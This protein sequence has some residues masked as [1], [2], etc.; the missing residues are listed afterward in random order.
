[1]KLVVNATEL[2]T[3]AIVDL[4]MHAAAELPGMADVM[5]S[6][7]VEAVQAGLADGREVTPIL[8]L[9]ADIPRDPEPLVDALV[10]AVYRR[11]A[12]PSTTTTVLQDWRKGRRSEVREINGEVVAVAHRHGTTST[13]NARIRDLGLRI[14]AGDLAAGPENMSAL[15]AP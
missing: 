6:A 9:G 11:F 8:G 14:E 4:P 1:M 3:S 13:V 5:R 7:G 12:L 10:D 2:V 15:A